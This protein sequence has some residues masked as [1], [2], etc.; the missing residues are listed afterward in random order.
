ME[1]VWEMG[2]DHGAWW[3]GL[4]GRDRDRV[5][6]KSG[7][8]LGQVWGGDLG[9]NGLASSSTQ[10]SALAPCEKGNSPSNNLHS[11]LYMT[12]LCLDRCNNNNN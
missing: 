11:S 12:S 7:M 5:L 2:K 3:E 1:M 4:W 6:S 8:G 10:V 9:S